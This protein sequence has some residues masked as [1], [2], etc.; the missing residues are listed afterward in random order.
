MLTAADAAGVKNVSLTI[1]CG[2]KSGLDTAIQEQIGARPVVELSLK[3]DGKQTDW[4]NEKAPVTIT[5]PYKP[6][7]E[8]LNDPDGIIIW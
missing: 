4:S 1:A 7:T 3:A 6:T 2:D 8:E 5:I